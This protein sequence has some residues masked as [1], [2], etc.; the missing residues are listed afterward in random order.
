MNEKEIKTVIAD[1]QASPKESE[2]GVNL[3]YLT[4]N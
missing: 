1:I 4:C 2:W 3:M